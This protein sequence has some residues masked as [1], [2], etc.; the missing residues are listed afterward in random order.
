MKIMII[1]GTR[2]EIIRLSTTIRHLEEI[3]ELVL[4]HTGQ[5]YDY[6]LNKIFFEDLEL[7]EPDYYLEA[8]GDGPADT[9]GRVIH[10]SD[11][12]I[13]SVQPD[14]VF[15]LGDTNSSLSVISAK[16]RKVPVFH[17]EAGN[18]CFDER[19]PEEIN[20][21][22]VDHVADINLTYSDVAKQNLLAEGLPMDRIF[23][24]GSPMLDVLEFYKDRINNSSI[25]SKLDLDPGK[26]FVLS[27]H[28]EETVDDPERLSELLKSVKEVSSEYGYKVVFS[29]HPRTRNRLNRTKYQ[30]VE[31]LK[32]IK[33]LSFTDY[34]ALQKK[35][36]CVLSDSGTITEESA[37]LGFP[38]VNIRETHERQEGMEQAAVIMSGFKTA[39]MLTAV[40]ATVG[41]VKRD[42]TPSAYKQRGIAERIHRIIISYTGYVD[43]RVWGR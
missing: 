36:F 8:V 19:V 7:P 2:P 26:Y 29:V 14:S 33:P 38:A 6:E 34:I 25:V 13:A 10:R 15:V 30:S 5:N 23:N 41:S 43:R 39:T 27:A 20:R 21:K 42:R 16:R 28:R 22:I 18:R 40:R 4:V 35:A 1:V 12:V 9:I 17:Y 32:C 24:I 11:E 37:I 31:H 3:G